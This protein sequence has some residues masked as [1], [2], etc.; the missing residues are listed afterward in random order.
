[1]IHCSIKNLDI[2]R[3]S[4]S[5]ILVWA[6]GVTAFVTSYFIPVMDDPDAQANW[7]LTVALI[8]ATIL[9]A[10]FYYGKGLCTNGF[11]LGIYMFFITMVLDASITV[12]VFIFPA[13]GN[14]LSFFG[15]PAFWAIGLEYICVVAAYWIIQ[16][17]VRATGTRQ[18]L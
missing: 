6:M 13:G 3:A 5:A 2:K 11:L 15:D 8:P 18:A 1:L 14:H 10:R 4:L 16:Y 7:V 17:R 9:G 12:P